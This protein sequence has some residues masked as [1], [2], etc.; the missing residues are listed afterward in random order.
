MADQHPLLWTPSPERIARSR[1]HD[2]QQWLAERGKSFD[3][4]NA[5]WH[6]SVE[7]IEEFWASVW[8]Y[9][10]IPCSVPY[11]R[12]L[13]ERTMPGAIW[14]EDCRL[15]FAEQLF[16]FNTNAGT[17]DKPAV[18]AESETRA[19]VSL[20]WQQLRDQVTAVANTLRAMGVQPGDRVA[21]YLPNTPEAVVAFFA[22]AS[23]GAIWSSCSPDMGTSSVLDRFQQI[24]PKVLIAVDGYRYGGKDFDRMNVVTTL[25]DELKTLQHTVLFPYL[26]TAAQLDGAML[27]DELFAHPASH[28][29]P[30]VFEQVPPDHPLWILYSSGTTGMPKPIVHGHAGSLVEAVKGNALSLDL[31]EDDRFLWFTTTGWVM[32]NAQITALLVG[33]TICIYDG[34]P[35]YPD[36]SRLWRFAEDMKLTF[37]GVG[38]AFYANCMKAGIEP[39]KI[40]DLSRLR[41]LGSTG[42]PLAD[43]AFH[44]I[45]E[46]VHSDIMLASISGGT[47]VVASFVGACPVLP[48]YAG[49]MQCRSLG[50]AVHAFNDQGDSVIDDVGEL[51]VTQPMPTMPLFFWNDP[52]NKRYL[53]SYFDHYP[54][55]WRHGDWIRITPRGGAIIYGRS[56]ATIN[57]YGIRMGTAEIYRVVD[58][59]PEVVDSMVVDLEYLGR[60]SYMPLFVVL[61]EGLTLDE[62]ITHKLR[63]KIRTQLSAR[64][65]PNDI[66]LVPEIPRTL[67]GKKMELPIKK[68]L[69]GTSIEKIANPDAMSNPQSLQWYA[70]FAEQR[71]KA[72]AN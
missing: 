40:A 21:A 34:N 9:F 8:D 66:F 37:M 63:E 18:I 48:I 67:T 32:W 26:D 24:E 57:R 36:M 71:L 39:S 16:R 61:R 55:V 59:L 70:A 17:G 13:V 33:S 43:E 22:C 10:E 51:V 44:W 62:D 27:W 29:S 38:A 69:L 41:S 4:Y 64:Y 72:L 31:G 47:D 46:N 35:G 15:N 3:D 65:L 45:Y 68:L 58:E 25:R 20:S 5:L 19:R 56:D 52:G 6:W 12:V 30:M 42:S 7:N 23:V 53:D 11:K 2:Y 50:I 60:E 28:A 54:G 49:E 14:F 1:L